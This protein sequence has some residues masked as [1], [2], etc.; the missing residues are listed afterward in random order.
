MPTQTK[1]QRNIVRDQRAIATY[2]LGSQGEHPWI[3]KQYDVKT[4]STKYWCEK[5]G[6]EQWLTD[7]ELASVYTEIKWTIPEH[8]EGE[9]ED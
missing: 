9:H 4:A 7:T 1:R 8:C 3:L 5:C 2:G 6:W